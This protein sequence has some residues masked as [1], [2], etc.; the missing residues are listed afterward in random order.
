MSSVTL[1]GE[2]LHQRR[3]DLCRLVEK[4]HDRNPGVRGG[5]RLRRRHRENIWET[6]ADIK[7]TSVRLC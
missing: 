4:K 7:Y 6:R 3:R 2:P 1:T 5:W